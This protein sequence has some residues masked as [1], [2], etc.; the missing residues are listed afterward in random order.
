MAVIAVD[1]AGRG[2]SAGTAHAERDLR[3]AAPAKAVGHTA[4]GSRDR[5]RGRAARAAGDAAT[6]RRRRSGRATSRSATRTARRCTVHARIVPFY[7]AER[8]ADRDGRLLDRRDR[9]APPRSRAPAQRAGAGISRARERDPRLVARPAPSRCSSSP[10]SRCPSSATAAW[11][12][13]AV[14]TARSSASRRRR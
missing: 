5:A 10:S 8:R 2:A 7:D 14:R 6:C 3:L 9:G 11:S 4:R 13:C 1:P 12:T